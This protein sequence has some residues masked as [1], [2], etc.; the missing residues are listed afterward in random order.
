MAWIFFGFLA[1]KKAF[2]KRS[3]LMAINE[4]IGIG[5]DSRPRALNWRSQNR[6]LRSGYPMTV[7]TRDRRRND[8]GTGSFT[9]AKQE[10]AEELPSALQL[11]CKNKQQKRK[12]R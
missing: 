2:F 12:A 10:I 11:M 3:D 9:K 7:G 5:L 4:Q 8:M 1:S 6:L